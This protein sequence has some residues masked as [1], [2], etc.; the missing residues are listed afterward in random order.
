M[1]FPTQCSNVLQI[2]GALKWSWYDLQATQLHNRIFNWETLKQIS[3]RLNTKGKVVNPSH[4]I[5]PFMILPVG[6]VCQLSEGAL[7]HL[8]LQLG[9]FLYLSLNRFSV[10]CVVFQCLMARRPPV[11]KSLKKSNL[12][13]PP[14][15]ANCQLAL[16]GFSGWSVLGEQP[17]SLTGS[18]LQWGEDSIQGNVRPGGGNSKS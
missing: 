9:P 7:A 3:K 4:T 2:E 11:G 10:D 18:L 14:N 5:R 13:S 1:T 6:Q 16:L 15:V 17:V 12:R 8:C